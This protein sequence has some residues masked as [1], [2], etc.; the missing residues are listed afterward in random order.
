MIK[1]DLQVIVDAQDVLLD[2]AGISV[3]RSTALTRLE[4]SLG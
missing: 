3:R 2:S 4:S 1:I